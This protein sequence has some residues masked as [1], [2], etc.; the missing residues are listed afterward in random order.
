MCPPPALYCVHQN[1]NKIPPLPGAHGVLGN[2]LCAVGVC[3]KG[4]LLGQVIDA[5]PHYPQGVLPAR[6]RPSA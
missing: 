1:R 2:H 6:D 3:A 4:E 5:V